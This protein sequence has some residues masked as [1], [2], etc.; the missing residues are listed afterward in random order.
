MNLA[1]QDIITR[2]KSPAL[3]FDGATKSQKKFAAILLCVFKRRKTHY[4]R[5]LKFGY[6]SVKRQR[7]YDQDVKI[8][9]MV[10]R[11]SM[12]L[13]MVKS[14]AFTKIKNERLI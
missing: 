7:R 1:V 10:N 12:K 5:S 13:L 9:Q 4:F 14:K 3:E 8:V 2:F 11:L 6:L